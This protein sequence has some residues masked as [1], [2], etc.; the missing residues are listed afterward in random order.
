M[1]THHPTPGLV[2]WREWVGLPALGV[3][4]IKAKVD[5]GAQT[6]ALHAFG[7][8]EFT[9][10]GE[11]WVKFEA[12]PWQRSARDGAAVE[13]PVHDRRRVRS[14]SGELQERIVVLIDLRMLDQTFP[15]EVTLTRRDA[16][17]FRLLVGREALRGRFVVDPAASFLGGRPPR[18]VRR[19]NRASA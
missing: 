10:S 15:V 13:L 18:P 3:E 9:R 16:M 11:Q 7:L 17:G 2:G 6:S 4:W 14:S 5:T 12:H 8:R 1:P 19:A